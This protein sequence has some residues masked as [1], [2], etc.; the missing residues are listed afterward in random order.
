M[1]VSGSAYKTY[2]SNRPIIA[3]L[4]FAEVVQKGL[5]GLGAI[6]VAYDIAPAAGKKALL[7]TMLAAV[8]EVVFLAL[9]TPPIVG[10]VAAAAAIVKFI[11]EEKV[12]E[13]IRTSSTLGIGPET[14]YFYVFKDSSL[15]IPAGQ[16]S[17]NS[18]SKVSNESF[19]LQESK[20]WFQ[21]VDWLAGIPNFSWVA[22]WEPMSPN[23]TALEAYFEGDL[24]AYQL[25]DSTEV[26][27][28]DENGQESDGKMS[29]LIP[30]A[31]IG[32]GLILLGGLKR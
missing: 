11:G 7:I 4:L 6:P 20:G 29:L 5:P 23:I 1:L 27:N 28:V 24:A 16:Y 26:G 31:G 3:A 15:G 17:I 19:L 32:I 14:G 21:Y 22:R 2:T 12:V 18:I 10:S 13:A 9:P 25:W 8:I 30:L